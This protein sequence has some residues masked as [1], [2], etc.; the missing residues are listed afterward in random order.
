MVLLPG[1]DLPRGDDDN[2][3]DDEV[4]GARFPEEGQN[5]W[6]AE[7]AGERF[8]LLEGIWVAVVVCG[9]L[10]MAIGSV[11]VDEDGMLVGAV[12]IWAVLVLLSFSSSSS[13]WVMM[14]NVEKERDR[15]RD[16][17]CG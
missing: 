9:L 14:V 11:I 7:T 16:V 15:E 3:D 12:A 5:C 8:M 6:K 2:E 4:P 13:S 10:L 1:E 17:V